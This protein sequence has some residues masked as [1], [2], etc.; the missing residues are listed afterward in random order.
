MAPGEAVRAL[1]YVLTIGGVQQVVLSTSDLEARLWE[2]TGAGL[3][4]LISHRR[5][6]TDE[7]DGPGGDQALVD[8]LPESETERILVEIW[9]QV[10]GV[11]Q[12]S[13]HDTFLDLGGNSL[14]AIQVIGRIHEQLSAPVVIEEFIFQTVRQL[15]A[16]CDARQ[17]VAA[18][19]G[20]GGGA[21]TPRRPWL[22]V[23]RNALRGGRTE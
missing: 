5:A 1:G 9:Q 4:R 13:V 2:W 6:E 16:I 23:V 12:V 22:R 20:A 17:P 19:A 11:E 18:V 15:A 10:L 14:S 21:S 7:G 8:G 3:R